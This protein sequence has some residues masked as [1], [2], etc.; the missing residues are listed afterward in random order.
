VTLMSSLTR[1]GSSTP[2]SSTTILSLPWRWMSGSE[3]P[4]VLMR[5]SIVSRAWLTDWSRR[6]WATRGLSVS[7]PGRR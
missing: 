5:L 6:N 2:G 7:W 1:S 3:T 4:K